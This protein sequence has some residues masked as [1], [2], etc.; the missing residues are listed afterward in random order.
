MRIKQTLRNM[1]HILEP[2][3]IF[4][5]FRKFNIIREYGVTANSLHWREPGLAVTQFALDALKKLRSEELKDYCQNYKQNLIEFLISNFDKN[6]GGFKQHAG[7]SPTIYATYL[8]LNI[9]NIFH[10]E[11]Y[12]KDYFEPLGYKGACEVLGAGRIV[13]IENFIKSSQDMKTGGFLEAPGVGY[14]ATIPRTNA[15]FLAL[16]HLE[17]EIPNK[18]KMLEFLTSVCLKKDINGGM[19]F[20]AIPRGEVL[21]CST[22]F[23]LKLLEQL[24]Q[25][26]WIEENKIPLMNFLKS[27]WS[28]NQMIG[29]FGGKFDTPP[30]IAH[31]CLVIS[32][33]SEIFKVRPQ[34]IGNPVDPQKIVNFVKSCQSNGGFS[35]I[36]KI[37]P[38]AYST[39]NAIKLMNLL[40]PD[41][42]FENL[43][44]KDMTTNYFFR[45]LLDSETKIFRG[46]ENYETTRFLKKFRSFTDKL[47][48]PKNEFKKNQLY[49]F[50]YFFTALFSIPF[51]LTGFILYLIFGS[52]TA[53]YLGLGSLALEISA[54]AGIIKW[55]FTR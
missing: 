45:S 19:G 30:T 43:F 31:T 5:E 7:S 10:D 40:A 35:F 12:N 26:N 17:S 55:F 39:R 23:S 20:S 13:K 22:W 51:I 8:A 16:R 4:H 21:S 11:N 41:F 47:F 34:D 6:A 42:T 27:C 44:N 32:C 48:K 50:P 54:I 14:Q 25:K 53:L 24:D 3:L 9:I 29:G 18:A 49:P 38:D 37:A 52:Y 36:K 28:E 15:A 46:Y 2:L 33:F 1:S